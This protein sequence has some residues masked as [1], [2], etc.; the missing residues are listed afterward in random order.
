MI[1]E[2]PPEIGASVLDIAV[3]R[4]AEY[5]GT[6]ASG[7]WRL[8]SFPG[9]DEWA[10]RP[11]DVR[12]TDEVHVPGGTTTPCPRAECDECV[13]WWWAE[14]IALD[15]D[16]LSEAVDCRLYF[17]RHRNTAHGGASEVLSPSGR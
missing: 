4:L 10:A 3:G 6:A 12:R 15:E 2:T 5:R 8:R 16:E 13:A 11:G 7:L 14:Q 9:T 1:G 17:G